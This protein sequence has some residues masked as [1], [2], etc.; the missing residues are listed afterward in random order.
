MLEWTGLQGLAANVLA[1]YPF[2]YQIRL[3]EYTVVLVYCFS[4]GSSELEFGFF[5]HFAISV[6]S[7]ELNS[8]YSS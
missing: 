4:I 7:I 8:L 3:S 2:G 5:S 6:N 1:Y